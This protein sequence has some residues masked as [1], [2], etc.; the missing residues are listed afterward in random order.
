[1]GWVGVKVVVLMVGAGVGG[2]LVRGGWVVYEVI[3]SDGVFCG[4][5]LLEL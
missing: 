2:V 4:G 5:L 3:V 1:M